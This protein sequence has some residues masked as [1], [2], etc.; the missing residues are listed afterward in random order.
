MHLSPGFLS[1]LQLP[2]SHTIQDTCTSLTSTISIPGTTVTSAIR[3]PAGSNIT[4]GGDETCFTPYQQNA[5]DICRVNGVI[6]TSVTSSVKFEMWLPEIWYGRFLVTGNG[7]LGGCKF[8]NQPAYQY[9]LL[10]NAS[11]L[12]LPIPFISVTSGVDYAN[13]D[14]GSYLHFATIGTNNGHDGN[15]N[16]PAFLMPAMRESI[17]DFSH[18]SIHVAAQVGKKI[19]STYYG[20]DPH[21]SY[22]DGCSAG[23]RQ[24]I[25]SA[26]HYPDD[27][28]G[29]IA[30]APGIDWNGLLGSSAIWASHVAFNTSS[31]IPTDVWETVVTPEILRQCD[32][33]D[34]RVD[35]IIGNPDT[36]QFD[37]ATLLCTEKD[38]ADP[39]KCLIQ[40]QVEG[41]KEFYK[42]IYGS[43]GN[44]LYSR[45]DPGAEGDLSFG[46]GMSGTLSPLTQVRSQPTTP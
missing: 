46:F 17:T 41:L 19:T 12:T 42:P 35:G 18:R 14:H 3:Y 39:S 34:G 16:A 13:L 44:L 15:F 33:L 2:I 8:S 7:G 37:P 25:S 36:C 32:A 22:Y 20:S 1:A 24:G 5:V 6:T 40:P 27:F 21:H 23:G 26:A 30:G 29:I 38:V 45:F 9:N 10:L 31:Y 4:T 43:R 11:R 28:D